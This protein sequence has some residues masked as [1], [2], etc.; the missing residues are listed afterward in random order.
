MDWRLSGD[1]GTNSLGWCAIELDAR[2]APFR[3][4][5]MGSRIFSDG[6]D[7]KSKQ[8][9]AVDRREAR[10]MRR[11]RD[12]FKQRQAAVL[13]HLTAAGLFPPEADADAREAL[14]A[15]D[16]YALR[17]RA[18][19]ERL[20]PHE[21]GRALFHL[22]QRRG[23]K[24]NRRADRKD[25]EKGKIS[26]GVKRLVEA[27]DAQGARTYGEFLHLRRQAAQDP[28]HI[29]GVR[30][31]MTEDGEGY[32]FY[33]SRALLE[34][35]F[36]EITK[37]QAAFHPD[38]LGEEVRA[39][40]FDVIFHQRP[41]KTP[42]VGLCTLLHET[43]E[44]RLPKAHPL[45]Q[46]RRMLEEVNALRIVRAG[47]RAEPLSLDQRNT[48][49]LKLKDKRS[50]TFEALRK[51]LKLDPAARFNK[52]GENRKELK[53]DEVTASLGDKK[54][55][56]GR[57]VLLSAE[58]QWEVV[59]RVMAAESEADET[60]L[61]A[62]LQAEHRLTPDQARAVSDAP[63][64]EGYGRF[65]ETATKDLIEVLQA[66]VVV[67]S[68]AV[69]ELGF[70]H[71]DFRTGEVFDELPYY[72][73]VLERHILPGTATRTIPTRCATAS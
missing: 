65:G 19:D 47:E 56:G 16:P 10:A 3:I 68:Q 18:L 42:K 43:G 4:L 51:T 13:K 41:L 11:R 55:F 33:P 59:H 46:R 45:F 64:P 57:W 17:A 15:L 31:R 1:L 38:L 24:S 25:S 34:E 20:E 69:E 27:M 72:G 61:E 23:F 6:R 40:L 58:A 5:A 12:R 8:S 53:G 71:S 50:V 32:D 49:I 36:D 37:A 26:S 30:T 35:E 14:E 2:G 22:N 48:L 66:K 52:E 62:W 70:H 29:P 73:E 60:A 54:R 9:L 67:Y 7:P 21:V 63:L 39:T 28:N 44:T